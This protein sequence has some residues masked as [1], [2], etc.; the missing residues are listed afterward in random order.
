MIINEKQA[1]KGYIIITVSGDN[2][3]ALIPVENIEYVADY[4]TTYETGITF[5]SFKTGAKGG[6][7]VLEDFQTVCALVERATE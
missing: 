5:I 6:F 4:S 1:V 2:L 7:T 3:K